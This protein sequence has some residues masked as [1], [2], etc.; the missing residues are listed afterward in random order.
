MCYFYF[1]LDFLLHSPLNCIFEQTTHES[2][3][4]AIHKSVVRAIH[5]SFVR[6][7]HKS[8]VWAI[9]K[10]FVS[11]TLCVRVFLNLDYADGA[12]LPAEM[13]KVLPLSGYHA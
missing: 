7:I 3:V 2:F 13:L 1:T 10:G 5:E 9:H 11:A 4:R 12:A 8:V 6:A